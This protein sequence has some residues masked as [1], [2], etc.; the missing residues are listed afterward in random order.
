MYFNGDT[1]ARS[2]RFAIKD[3]LFFE[4]PIPTPNI[5]EQRKIGNYIETLAHLITLHQRK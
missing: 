3:T 4:M 2:D 5:D 1:G